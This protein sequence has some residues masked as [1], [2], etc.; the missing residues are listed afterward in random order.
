MEVVLPGEELP[1]P[2]GYLR[3][4][5]TTLSESTGGLR[6][7]VVGTVERVSKLVSVRPPRARYAGAVGD[8]VVGRITEVGNKRWKV[9]VNARQE[10][11]LLL[12]AINL[13]GGAQRRRTLEDQLQMRQL[14]AENDVVSCEVSSFYRDGGMA[15]QTRSLKY[16]KLENGMLVVVPP[17]L[18]KRL[19]H[20]FV[21]L[22]CGVNVVLGCNGYLWLTAPHVAVAVPASAKS[23]KAGDEEDDEDDEDDASRD[24]A[25]EAVADVE[26][27]RRIAEMEARRAA[28]AKRVIT[29]E[30]RARIARVHDVVRV[31]AWGMVTISPRSIE[32]AYEASIALAPR[33][34]ALL[35]P[36][37]ASRLL[38]LLAGLDVASADV[39]VDV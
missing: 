8:V 11:V 22:R 19:K 32:A 37:V 39:D 7:S 14:F 9:D 30:E 29:P 31:L 21:T 17:G 24:E 15:V 12:G 36:E 34:H 10:A 1:V 3:G 26:R 35:A 2:S 27:T 18:V 5:G 6:A 38:E 23:A 28:H 33:P 20:H 25:D 13:P 16:G 4:H